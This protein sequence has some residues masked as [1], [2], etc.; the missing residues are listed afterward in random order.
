MKTTKLSILFV[1][2]LFV[3]ATSI[4]S[5]RKH[6][7][8]KDEDVTEAA[9]HSYAEHASSDIINIGSQASDNSTGNLST[10]RN[11]SNED[12]LSYCA[13][14]KRDTINH[15][16]SVIFNNSTCLDGRLRNGILIFNY[17]AS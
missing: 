12:I 1:A 10:Y 17:L 13:T 8:E 9:D 14:V 5:C 11:G 7:E 16:D 4:T 15:I 6:K 2:S 3:F